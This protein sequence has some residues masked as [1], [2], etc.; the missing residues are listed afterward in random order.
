MARRRG[1]CRG[2]PVSMTALLQGKPSV[3]VLTDPHAAVRRVQLDHDHDHG[4]LL[5]ARW[6][7]DEFILL[8]PPAAAT[9][10]CARPPRGAGG[11]GPNLRDRPSRVA[12]DAHHR[13]GAGSAGRYRAQRVA[14]WAC[15]PWSRASRHR[16]NRPHWTHGGRRVPGLPLRAADAGRRLAGLAAPL[17]RP[18][19]HAA[20]AG[21]PGLI[22]PPAAAGRTSSPPPAQRAIVN[23][24]SC[25]G[26][27]SGRAGCLDSSLPTATAP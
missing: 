18:G 23:L 3:P 15:A 16:R 26:G 13:R 10:R 25:R 27:R 1:C 21:G 4:G 9:P 11:A 5:L 12:A 17:A 2:P 6:D 14:A 19:P 8:L 7:S 22:V 20:V 24:P